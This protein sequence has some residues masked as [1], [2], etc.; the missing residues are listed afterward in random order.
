MNISESYAEPSLGEIILL[1]QQ[2]NLPINDIE[3]GKQHFIVSRIEDEIVGCIG[4][5]GY[6]ELGLIRSLSVKQSY[7]NKG[8]GKELYSKALQ[9]CLEKGFNKIYL[10]TT[11]A[12][13]YF[14]A[15]GWKRIDRAAVPKIMHTSKEFSEICPTTAICMEL[16]IIPHMAGKI[17]ADGFNCAQAVFYPFAIQAGFLPEH[18]LKLATGF[19]AGMV[20]QGETCG[21][22]TGAMMAIG[23][24]NGR[25]L[26]DDYDSK[27]K[28]YMLINEMYKRFINIH[29]SILCKELLK[30]EN[31]QPDSWANANNKGLFKS[32]CP[33]FVKD[34]A[35]IVDDLL[36]K[37]EK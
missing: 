1:L 6:G 32:H 14:E 23:I 29:G 21:A 31:S 9:Y 4:I 15:K 17:F 11:T 18:A 35:S 33:I 16:S 28:T 19:G 37:T 3:P 2:N 7:Q 34:A 25:S 10:L 27:D 5:E 20:Y 26:A 22:I 30:L 24:K 36:Q 12:A 13:K 8:V